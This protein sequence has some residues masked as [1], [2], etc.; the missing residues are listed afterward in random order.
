MERGRGDGARRRMRGA[1]LALAVF[2]TALGT[3]TATASAAH[4][5]TV[6][7]TDVSVE[8][9]AMALAAP[10][11]GLAATPSG[12]GYWRVGADGGVLT[13][14]D[15]KFYGSAVGRAHDS[16]VAIAATR[17]GHGYWLTDRLG[18]V[19]T[20]GD[21]AFHGSM[22]GHPLNLPIVG[23]AATPSGTGYWLVASDGGIFSFNAPVPRLDRCDASQPTDR[24]HVRDARRQ[25]LLARRERRRDLLVQRAVLRLD[26][27]VAPQPTHHRDGGRADRQRLHHG[28]GRR[29]A[30]PL[31]RREPVLRLGRQRVPRST[32]GC[33][34]DVARRTRLL[35]RLRRRPHLR[36]L[37]DIRGAAMQPTTC[38]KPREMAA[39][40]F[41]RIN[42]E[43]ALRHLALLTWDPSLASYAAA[44]SANMSAQRL[45]AQRDREP[46][47]PIQLR[48]R[49]H[50]GRQ[51]GNA[52]RRAARRVDALRRPP[53]EH[54]R[55]PA[56]PGSVSACSARPTAR[57]G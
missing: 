24:R 56:S 52:R 34:G 3:A 53:R 28:R 13:A 20:F 47:R 4:A 22:A 55:T 43:R 57:S 26:R 45:P 21:A 49:E 54:P 8:S 48:R 29:R 37:A 19:F 9:T 35:D 17:T 15:A 18:E 5:S 36:V 40:L 44:W 41:V 14:G 38:P 30:L 25:R 12:K 39:D 23:M 33:G 51:P 31:R 32:R 10:V 42:D 50:R 16:I 27:I 6:Q 2:A 11:V 1:F 46:A 7:T